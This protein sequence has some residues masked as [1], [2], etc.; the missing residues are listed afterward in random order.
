MTLDS[1]AP[2][3][4]LV[5]SSRA[6]LSPAPTRAASTRAAAR[7]AAALAVAVCALAGGPASASA[8]AIPLIES[9]DPTSGPP[10]TQVTVVGRNF[11]AQTQVFLGNVPL[12]IVSRSPARWVVR[13]PQGAQTAQLYVRNATGPST[14][15]PTFRITAPPAA[16]VVERLEPPSGPPGTE[17]AIRG[18]NFSARIPDNVVLL[19]DRP[20]V[21]RSATPFD[22]RVLV[23]EGAATG[24]VTVRVAGAGEARSAQ[25]FTVTAATGITDFQPR[26]GPPGTRVTLTGTGFSPTKTFNRVF[27]NNLPVRVETAS[28]TRLEVSIPAAAATGPLTVD[29]RGGARMDTPGPFVVALPPTIIAVEPPAAPPGREVVVRGT[30]FGGDVRA[31]DLRLGGTPL[32]VRAV[33]PTA[34]TAVLPADLPAQSARLNLN[35]G[36]LGPAQSPSDFAVLAPLVITGFSPASGPAGTQVT[37][38]GTGFGARPQDVAATIS[39]ARCEV[40][41]VAPTQLVLRVPGAQSGPLEVTVA[42]SGTVRTQTPFVVTRPPFVAGFEPARVTVGGTVRIRGT[43]F[44]T[45][46]ALVDVTVGGARVE[47]VALTDTEITA[48]IPAGTPSGPVSVTVRLQGS[49]STSTALTVDAPLAVTGFSPAEGMVGATVTVRGEGFGPG[50]VVLFGNAPATPS[51]LVP[52]ELRVAVPAGATSGPL[53]V[54]TPDGRTAAS[55]TPFTVQAPPAGVGITAVRA[56]CTRPGC[57]VTLV[58]HGFSPRA[59]WNRVFFGTAPVRVSAARATELV[60]DLPARPGTATFRVDVRRVGAAESA[61]FT[62][63]P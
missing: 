19:G 44:G 57:Q 49:S 52:T 33:T 3:P 40:V 8:Q 43:G 34:I 27:M 25:P 21:V 7:L 29:V 61:P 36:G 26:I 22:L 60:V 48:R 13:I 30:N 24:P 37:L 42:G 62:V 6:P 28:A 18:Q 46:P 63:T 20:L 1:H 31:V 11:D 17:L 58:G 41:S 32:V 45:Q 56:T 39:G 55:A 10:G 14:V 38:T 53:T 59:Q 51:A 5:T 12:E 2:P 23:P 50:V 35:V 54:R 15:N 9:I 4:R 47:V 16:P